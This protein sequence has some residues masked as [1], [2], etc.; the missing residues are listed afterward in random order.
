MKKILRRL[1]GEKLVIEPA[2]KHSRPEQS[3]KETALN[4]T[5]SDTIGLGLLTLFLLGLSQSMQIGLGSPLT[6]ENIK[7]D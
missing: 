7:H 6:K 1:N 2:V 3:T 4:L 5:T